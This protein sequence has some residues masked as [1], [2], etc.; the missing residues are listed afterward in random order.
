MRN[1][2]FWEGGQRDKMD[3][4]RFG[5]RSKYLAKYAAPFSY[6]VEHSYSKHDAETQA[7]PL[8]CNSLQDI[9]L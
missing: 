1:R 4:P 7:I 6:A 8:S 2:E 5:I 9:T 3:H